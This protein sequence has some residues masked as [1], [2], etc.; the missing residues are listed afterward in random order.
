MAQERPAAAPNCLTEDEIEAAKAICEGPSNSNGQI[1][2]GFPVG[3]EGNP[4]G[5]ALWIVDA[6][7]LLGPGIPDLHFGFADSFF[8]FLADNDDGSFGLHDSTRRISTT[9]SRSAGS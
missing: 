8:R 6:E 1:F 4:Q 7:N 5:R 2:P 9:C 3:N